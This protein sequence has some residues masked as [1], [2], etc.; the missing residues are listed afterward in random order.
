M[1]VPAHPRIYHSVHQ[2]RLPSI[3][4]DGSLLSDAEMGQHQRAGTTIGMSEI[5]ARRLHELTLNSHPDLKVGQCVPFYFCPR[6]VMLY[7]IHRSNHQE[8]TYHDGQ[9]PIVHP[10]ADLKTVVNWA[11]ENDRRWAFTLSNAGASYFEDRCNLS[12]LD[13]VNWQAVHARQ[14][15]GK[16]Q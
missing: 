8:L 6:S 14:W 13:E 11:H 4:A 2:D 10:E 1:T 5:K 9:E 12:Q 3:I 7:V 16:P 15:S